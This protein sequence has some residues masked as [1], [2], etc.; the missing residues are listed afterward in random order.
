[1]PP[2]TSQ[3]SSEWRDFYLLVPSR[4]KQTNWERSVLWAGVTNSVPAQR[5]WLQ[6]LRMTLSHSSIAEVFG[7]LHL[8]PLEQ[9]WL[10]HAVFS[11]ALSSIN[12]VCPDL[13]YLSGYNSP[14]LVKPFL[15]V[16]L[17]ENVLERRCL[18]CVTLDCVVAF[19]PLKKLLH[20]TLFHSFCSSFTGVWLRLQKPSLLSRQKVVFLKYFPLPIH[21]K[22]AN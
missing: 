18:N 14:A 10:R 4:E 20:Q 22:D 6:H 7:E 13:N 8:T 1:M 11:E 9:H 17:A 19:F 3:W 12:D 5:T 15:P 21:L 2:P 16:L